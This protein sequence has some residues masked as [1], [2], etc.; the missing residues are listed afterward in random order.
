MDEFLDTL[1]N[2]VFTGPT[3]DLIAGMPGVMK[4]IVVIVGFV[5]AVA[6]LKCML[7]A[8]LAAA[9][10]WHKRKHYQGEEMSA[11]WIDLGWAVCVT[12]LVVII[13]FVIIAI[14]RAFGR[15]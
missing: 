12:V 14:L 1:L 8:I 9:N 11:A 4:F 3:F 6:I 10:V 13:P 2:V 15:I 5:W 7:D